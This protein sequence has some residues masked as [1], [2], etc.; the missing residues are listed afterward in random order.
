MPFSKLESMAKI[1]TRLQKPGARIKVRGSDD[2]YIDLDQRELRE[3]T[4]DRKSVSQN[5]KVNVSAV[6]TSSSN[7]SQQIQQII[8]QLD[9]KQL[10]PARLETAKKQLASFEEELQRSKPRWSKVKE[11]LRWALS[12]GEE[13]FLRLVMM[14][15]QQHGLTSKFG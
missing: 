4:K 12:L 1:V 11:I 8:M 9:Q 2:S 13:L 15:A 14:W 3:A 7:V 6:A 5:V 10:D